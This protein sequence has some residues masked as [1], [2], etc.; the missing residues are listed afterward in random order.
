MIRRSA[1]DGQAVERRNKRM[2][3]MQKRIKA[4]DPGACKIPW[5][6]GEPD[7]TNILQGCH[8]I[9]QAA[10]LD[11]IAAD[12]HVMHWWFDPRKI[13]EAMERSGMMAVET[14]EPSKIPAKDCTTRYACNWHDHDVYDEIDTGNL[15]VGR[16]G[17]RFL[18]GFRAMA[19]SLA[20]WQAPIAYVEE[21]YPGRADLPDGFIA[22]A[23]LLLA[24][25][26][27][28]FAEWQEAYRRG[29]YGRICAYH[30]RARSSVRCAGTSTV[31]I[32]F[33][34]LGT[35]TLL[36]EVVNG[37]LTG[38]YDIIVVALKKSWRDPLGR[39]LQMGALKRTAVTLKMMLEA[40]PGRALEWM[41]TNM[42]HVAVNPADYKS[43]D[44]I[45]PDERL[46]T[47]QGA[48]SQ[49]NSRLNEI[50]SARRV[51]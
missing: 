10:Y 21:A 25:A 37:D 13:F 38:H 20:A 42:N 6:P 27:D 44:L 26:E 9:S 2:K 1:A 14:L 23:E 7:E 3:R 46:R 8:I 45:S 39:L 29:D 48:A 50:L 16:A 40:S 17:H 34:D 32:G 12:H 31:D 30:V 47:E 35:L 24:R 11:H 4:Q 43:D 28:L 41:A 5:K 15:D 22:D 51:D 18:L 33:R 19:G 49:I 36:P